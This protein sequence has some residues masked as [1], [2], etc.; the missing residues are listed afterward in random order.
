ML[1][2]D[3]GC[4]LA[5]PGRVRGTV[6]GRWVLAVGGLGGADKLLDGLAEPVPELSR[7]YGPHVSHVDLERRIQIPVAFQRDQVVARLADGF[8][9][10]VMPKKSSQICFTINML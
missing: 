7:Q 5:G 6:P 2:G 8:L 4:P 1:A 3:S 10:V 9:T